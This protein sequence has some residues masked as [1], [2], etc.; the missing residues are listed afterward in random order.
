MPNVDDEKNFQEISRKPRY[1]GFC[2]VENKV[3]PL[4][5]CVFKFA[6]E[7]RPCSENFRR[8]VSKNIAKLLLD[9]KTG[10]C[11]I[12]AFLFLFPTSSLFCNNWEAKSSGLFLLRYQ[13]NSAW[14]LFQSNSAWKFLAFFNEINRL[15][16]SLTVNFYNYEVK[17]VLLRVK[18]KIF[19]RRKIVVL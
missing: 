3:I 8:L 10:G 5:D 1:L 14:V 7:T 15:C 17:A 13:T 4:R 6:R 11:T 9:K 2:D 12:T 18:T 16:L 19:A